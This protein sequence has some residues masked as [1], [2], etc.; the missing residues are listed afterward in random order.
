EAISDE[1]RRRQR[2]TISHMA[3]DLARYYDGKIDPHRDWFPL[4]AM[5]AFS[6]LADH[7]RSL[8]GPE[9]PSFGSLACSC[10]PN[11]GSSVLIVANRKTGAW[12]TITQF[13]DME[14]FMADIAV[15]CDAARGRNLTLAQAALSFVRN[16]DGRKTPPGMNLREF[17][18]LFF[19]GKMGGTM[20]SKI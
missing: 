10:H 3:Y 18:K 11:C 2:Y 4:G 5:G 16:F 13:F 1:D 20:G 14:R 15:M 9:G 8:Q 19:N 7:L 6:A 12:S 17:A